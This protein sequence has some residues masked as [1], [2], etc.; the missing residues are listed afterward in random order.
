MSKDSK[1][2]NSK[3]YTGGSI[4]NCEATLGCVRVRVERRDGR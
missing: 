2:G 1:M 3:A 4:W